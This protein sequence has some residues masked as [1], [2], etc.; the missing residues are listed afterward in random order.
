MMEVTQASQWWNIRRAAVYL[1]M[2]VA[3][4]RKAVRQKSIPFVRAGSKALRFR[5]EDLD[6][7][8]ESN[9]CNGQQ[10]YNNHKG[11]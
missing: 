11:R 4:L 2:S 9:G 3:F 1:D 8:L 7:W 5:K 10:T 6:A